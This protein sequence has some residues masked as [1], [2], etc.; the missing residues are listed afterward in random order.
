MAFSFSDRSLSE[1]IQHCLGCGDL[2]GDAEDA[3]AD[4][5]PMDLPALHQEC[6]QPN[7]SLEQIRALLHEDGCD[8]N[9]I[10]AGSGR[11]PLHT[12]LLTPHTDGV[13]LV[14]CAAALVEAGA[15]LDLRDAT[16]STPINCLERLLSQGLVRETAAMCDLFLSSSATS[17]HGCDVNSM[18]GS[19]RT[20]LSHSV[21]Y[22]DLAA[23]VTRVLV[24]H[25]GRVWPGDS[26]TSPASVESLTQDREQ[27][28]FTW[29]LRTLIQTN[30]LA[31]A[32]ST[33]NSLSHEMGRD[34]ARMKSHVMRVM[35]AEGKH[36]KVLGPLY[37]KLKLAMCPFWDEP[38][39]L[40][41]LAWNSIRRSIGPKRLATSSKQLGLPLP[42][43]KYLTLS[44]SRPAASRPVP[45]RK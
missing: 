27:S 33:L 1:L 44:S 26:P 21:T 5:D 6:A 12:L 29:F 36:P 13:D 34:P 8:P 28:A 30:N 41:Y 7:P 20:L 14:A 2:A 37:L 3:A 24:N 31:G 17:S 18:D 35:L 10:L 39:H 9:Q 15:H 25:G 23:E 19:G 11:S 4:L 42:L 38:Q 40:R 16:G 45:A 32:E 43:R 22:L